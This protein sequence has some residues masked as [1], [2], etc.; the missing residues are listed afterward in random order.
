MN[1]PPLSL[2]EQQQSLR[3]NL[4]AVKILKSLD[5]LL[6]FVFTWRDAEGNNTPKHKRVKQLTHTSFT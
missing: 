5:L 6:F 1:G 2:E 4:L 3:N